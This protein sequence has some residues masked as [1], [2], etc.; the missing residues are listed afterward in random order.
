M[1]EFESIGSIPLAMA[2]VAMLYASAAS[3]GGLVVRPAMTKHCCRTDAVLVR[4]TVGMN[5]L[6]F[7]GVTLGQ[8]GIL[9]GGRSVW[10]LAAL[11]IW[12]VCRRWPGLRV[13]NG[14][15][16]RR[17]M[18]RPPLAE[19]LAI[20]IA[21]ITLGPALCY[22]FGW[23]ELVYHEALPKRWLAD[24]CPEVYPDLPYSGFP[25]FGEILFWL[26]APIESV[27]APRLVVGSCWLLGLLCLHRLLC[28]RLT[29]STAAM[30]TLAF[31]L[32][33]TV[34]L[35]SANCYVESILLMDVAALF[36]ALNLPGWRGK[37]QLG[38]AQAAV[39]G[40][41]AG[42]A[43]AI[44]LTGC[45]ILAVPVVWYSRQLCVDWR[46]WR[47]LFRPVVLYGTVAL[48]QLL[49]FYLR[50]WLATGNPFYPYFCSWFSNNAARWEMSRYHHLIG[51]FQF[52]D[53]GAMAF[54]VAPF[55]LAFRPEKYD[56]AFGWQMLV[57][58]VLAVIALVSACRRRLRPV[59]IWIIVVALWF[60]V[61]WFVTAQQARFAVQ[62]VAALTVLAGFGMR[63]LTAGW[64]Q[65]V[66]CSLVATVPFSIPWRKWDFYSASW[67]TVVG[68]LKRDD[69]VN[70]GTRGV[71][72]PLIRAVHTLTST[73]ARLMLLFEHRGFYVSRHYLIGT[74]LFQE[75][76][77][78][79]PEQ[80]ADVES[81]ITVLQQNE[82]THVVAAK[83]NPGP[84]QSPDWIQRQQP[85]LRALEQCIQQRRLLLRWES[86][87][88][89]L[90]EVAR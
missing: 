64:R 83:V 4:L 29:G 31:T 69:Y 58:E 11:S 46:R 12:C 27:I 53:T 86:E 76:P 45:A 67:L 81:V 36:L 21:A 85:F 90:L 44:K 28:R 82:I 74:P 73:D 24:G 84:D 10:L 23:D 65:L 39:L 54:L 18:E 17:M 50:P 14:A 77:F 66:L 60:Y 25:S 56:G 43:A 40:I 35:I 88:Y 32:N 22:P 79:P 55:H 61:F 75:G 51:G 9:S 7:V 57:L 59:V 26:A 87:D 48:C 16:L 62:F 70:Y 13:V 19:L 2:V 72:L 15:I 89:A 34:L 71:H 42:G 80:F 63:M 78:S 3:L 1:P 37:R 30:L 33:N 68:R 8:T 20:A 38:W 41:L 6:G 49:P 47:R 5:L 52:G